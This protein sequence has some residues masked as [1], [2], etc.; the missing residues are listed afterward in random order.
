MLP[1]HPAQDQVPAVPQFETQLNVT[2]DP[3]L[4][5]ATEGESAGPGVRMYQAGPQS[6]NVPRVNFH[7][8]LETPPELEGMRWRSATVE[9]FL[10]VTIM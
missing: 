7:P 2:C 10:R 6:K 5:T 4:T 9:A 1:A 8:P 3:W